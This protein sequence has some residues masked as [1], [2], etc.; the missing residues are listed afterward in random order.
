MNSKHASLVLSLVLGLSACKGSLNTGLDDLSDAGRSD[1]GI[2]LGPMPGGGNAGNPNGG[3]AAGGTGGSGGSPV[4]GTIADGSAGA[5][6]TGGNGGQA[7]TPV[8]PTAGSNTRPIDGG[9]TSPVLPID[10]AVDQPSVPDDRQP[11]AEIDRGRDDTGIDV[12][13]ATGGTSGNPDGGT[14]ATADGGDGD[15]GLASASA[16]GGDAAPV[17]SPVIYSSDKMPEARYDQTATL[18]NGG[19]V[20]IVGGAGLNGESLAS[21]VLFDLYA[22]RYDWNKRKMTTVGSM[23]AGRQEHTAT[24]LSD[25]RVLVTGDFNMPMHPSAAAVTAELYD[26]MTQKFSATGNM[27]MPRCTHTATLLRNGKV[28]ITGGNTMSAD[29]LTG[30]QTETAELYDPSTGKFKLTGSMRS[31]RAEHTATLL[32]NGKVLITGGNGSGSP[33]ITHASAELYD[34]ATGQ[35]SATGD[36]TKSRCWHK[37]T[38]LADGRVL[39]TG[40]VLTMSQLVTPLVAN[41]DVYDPATGK[42]TATGSLTTPRW[43]QSAT[44]LD[45]GKVL[46]VGGSDNY[47][48]LAGAELYDPATGIFTV[49]SVTLTAARLRHTATLLDSGQVLIAGGTNRLGDTFASTEMFGYVWSH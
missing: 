21:A 20:L 32:P 44:L 46:L 31:S 27:N 12:A 47:N 40:G 19:T 39:I 6:G 24:L 13:I 26:P 5:P 15:G 30:G 42:F 38:L 4:A 25:G 11:D 2:D 33:D 28:L 1:T 9:S 49:P 37:A 41:A 34:P 3:I 36:M 45:D 18:L 10:A 48:A 16:D 29:G 23:T 8:G 22:D 17:R 35:F 43:G 14:N 7:S